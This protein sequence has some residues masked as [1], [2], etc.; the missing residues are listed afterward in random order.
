MRA[1]IALTLTR[2]PRIGITLALATA[3][4]AAKKNYYALYLPG[5]G[6]GIFSNWNL[7]ARHGA[8]G[9]H[10]NIHKG[11]KTLDEAIEHVTIN[12]DGA[13]VPLVD[14]WYPLVGPPE[15]AT[16]GAFAALHGMQQA[17]ALTGRFNHAD[18]SGFVA[19]HDGDYRDAINNRKATVHLLVH[20]A[21]LG[22]MSPYA[23]R[24]L[25]RLARDASD[26]GT[27]G[28]DY[29]RSYTARSFVP[30]FAQRISTACVMEGAEGILK[31]IRKKSHAHLRR[32]AATA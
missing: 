14:V 9:A 17:T 21:T 26:N 24:R 2:R 30:Y 16:P 4:A 15:P 3:V 13:V 1:A 25:R 32:A 28:T 31:G 23:A 18:G 19:R 7:C 6:Y 27:D 5:L 10:H 29:T 11:Y 20:E 8:N 12:V 22:S